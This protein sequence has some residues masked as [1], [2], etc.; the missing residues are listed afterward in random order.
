MWVPPK[1]DRQ[2]REAEGTCLAFSQSIC[3]DRS[4]GRAD[5]DPTKAAV[6]WGGRGGETEAPIAWGLDHLCPRVVRRLRCAWEVESW[7]G[8]GRSRSRH[9]RVIPHTLPAVTRV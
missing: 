7:L 6:H 1:L 2:G 8:R 3:V 5:V 4:S 9:G